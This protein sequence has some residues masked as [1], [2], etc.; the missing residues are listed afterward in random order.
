MEVSKLMWREIRRQISF[1]HVGFEVTAEYPCTDVQ[2]TFGQLRLK[3][4]REVRDW[5]WGVF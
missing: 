1:Q 5:L 4:K 2:L 3:F